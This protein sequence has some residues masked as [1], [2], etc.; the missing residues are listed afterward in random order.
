MV[1]VYDE[2]CVWIAHRFSIPPPSSSLRMGSRYG[3]YQD[4]IMYRLLVHHTLTVLGRETSLH[5][6]TLASPAPGP[7]DAA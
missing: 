7:A 3:R 2:H 5:T 1:I 4:S 6:L